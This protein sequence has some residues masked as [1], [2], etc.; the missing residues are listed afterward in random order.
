VGGFRWPDGT[1]L[2]MFATI[3]TSANADMTRL[4]DRMPV[5]LD[6]ADWPASLGEADGDRAALL[7]PAPDGTLQS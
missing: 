3:S 7:R 2:R 5:I 4:H 1:V 6:R